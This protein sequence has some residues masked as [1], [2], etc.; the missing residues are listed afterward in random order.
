M[1]TMLMVIDTIICLLLIVSVV[2]QSSKSAGMG[3][4]ISGGADAVF[5]GKARGID[6][7]LA[8]ATMFLGALFA[9]I[10]LIIAKL[11]M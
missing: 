3:G 7:L 8:K 4:S 1:T 10:T 9:I 6:A 11:Q 5:G 2:L